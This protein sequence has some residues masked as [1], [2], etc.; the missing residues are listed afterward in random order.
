M[1]SKLKVPF[2]K[3]AILPLAM[4]QS[5]GG[6]RTF[7][8]ELYEDPFDLCRDV[9]ENFVALS[10]LLLRSHFLKI[11]CWIED[12]FRAVVSFF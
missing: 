3:S 12:E 9:F 7:N 5:H 11:S 1:S 4:K 2:R 8:N 10:A 6:V